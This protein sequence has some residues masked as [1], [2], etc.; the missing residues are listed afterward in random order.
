M[1]YNIHFLKKK[2]LND[3]FIN[4]SFWAVSGSIIYKGL[5]FISGLIIINYLGKEDFGKFSIIKAT[6]VAISTFFALGFNYVSIKFIADSISSNSRNVY[7]ICKFTGG[8][9]FI[10]ALS[11]MTLVFIFGNDLFDIITKIDNNTF[12]KYLISPFVFVFIMCSWSVGVLSGMGVYKSQAYVNIITGFISFFITLIFTFFYG[13][14]GAILALFLTYFI[15][16]IF[17]LIVVQKYLSKYKNNYKLDLYLKKDILIFSIPI[18]IQEMI[19]PLFV[20]ATN[21]VILVNNSHSAIG[22]FNAAIQWNAIVIII[23]AILKNVILSNL[24]LKSRNT[25]E[26]RA[27]INKSTKL[28]LMVSIF[29]CFLIFLIIKLGFLNSLYDSSYNGLDNLIL[30]AAISG[31]ILCISDVYLQ[32]LISRSKNW[33]VLFLKSLRDSF[34][35]VLILLL[36]SS[37]LAISEIQL[38]SAVLL[39]MAIT[40]LLFLV[41]VYIIYLKEIKC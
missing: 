27:I 16:L 21:Y 10:L 32:F 30:L 34:K 8:V 13:Y 41:S 19:Y 3:E 17:N 23:P 37:S 36:V 7:G 29:I 28:N 39:I 2:L 26:T 25:K 33:I 12:S 18:S 22:L 11:S 38:I 9:S 5:A 35:I 14:D 6:A 1:R 4:D 31:L 24:S 40:N 20:W 15:N